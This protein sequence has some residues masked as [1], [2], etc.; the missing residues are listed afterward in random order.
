MEKN[1][2]ITP[3]YTSLCLITPKRES[4]LG[5][6]WD[7]SH[8]LIT[9]QGTQGRELTCQGHQY[10]GL[11]LNCLS[12]PQV[13]VQLLASLDIKLCFILMHIAVER[14]PQVL[15]K[16]EH[17]IFPLN[18]LNLDATHANIITFF[19]FLKSTCSF[20]FLL[21]NHSKPLSSFALGHL[22]Q[23]Q[24]RS[25]LVWIC[26]EA[27]KADFLTKKRFIWFDGGGLKLNDL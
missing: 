26:W 6:G 17:C 10:V 14:F 5:R 18:I 15:F 7:V 27:S 24:M 4:P 9:P 25:V 16:A 21:Y 3:P 11:A 19:Y 2:V 12:L 1:Q 8:I 23:E 22:H 20:F 13:M